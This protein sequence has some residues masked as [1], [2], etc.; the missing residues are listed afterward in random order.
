LLRRASDLAEQ[1]LDDSSR[2]FDAA[3]RGLRAAAAL[4]DVHEW[5]ARVDRLATMPGGRA[6]QVELLTEVIPE[7]FDVDQQVLAQRR[8]AEIKRHD[9]EDLPGAVEAYKKA[10][11]L[12]PD[13][14]ASLLSLEAIY[15]DQRDYGALLGI[16]EQREEAAPD[17][18]SRKALAYRRAELLAD[19]LDEPGRA[20]E[21]YEAI[22]DLSLES[23][24]IE[25]VSALYLGEERYDDLVALLQR[26]IDEA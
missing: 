11:E 24:A 6:R 3:L 26:R 2:A 16:L 23:P 18:A 12:Q 21:T 19:R 17:D 4:G 9:L 25:A 1:A 7:L 14:E 5:L 10:L 20:I 15:Q 8:V 13:D 22:L